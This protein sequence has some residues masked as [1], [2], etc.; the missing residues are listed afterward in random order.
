M[1]I[2]EM[3]A[4]ME[5]ISA[6]KVSPAVSAKYDAIAAKLKAAE[7]LAYAAGGVLIFTD[8][9]WDGVHKELDACLEEYFNIGEK[10]PILITPTEENI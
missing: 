6:A 7:E 4:L 8:H 9:N 1:L 2:E 10:A 5:T 3:I